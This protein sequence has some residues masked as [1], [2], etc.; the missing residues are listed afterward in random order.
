[1]CRY[2]TPMCA[3]WNQPGDPEAASGP[4]LSGL[5]YCRTHRR[6][7][8]CTPWLQYCRAHVVWRI[9]MW[10]AQFT[11]TDGSSSGMRCGHVRV[12]LLPS[13]A[14]A[15]CACMYMQWLNA[16]CMHVHRIAWPQEYSRG[17]AATPQRGSSAAS[18]QWMPQLRSLSVPGRLPRGMPTCHSAWCRSVIRV[19]R[20][21]GAVSRGLDSGAG[22]SGKLV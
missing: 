11:S 5:Q 13:E 4:A 12:W 21:Q 14:R 20:A 10:M 2:T 9:C 15:G 22:Q 17:S 6:T 1:M 19:N 18:M 16:P 7:H 3:A 8:A